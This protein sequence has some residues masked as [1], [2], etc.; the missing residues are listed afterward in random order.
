MRLTTT[1]ITSF[2]ALAC[3]LPVQAA[4]GKFTPMSPHSGAATPANPHAGM[5]AN[6]HGAGMQ[7]PAAQGLA[8]K[9][10][11]KNVLDVPQFTYIEADQAGKSVWIAAPTTKLKKGDKI[12]YDNGM[13]MNNFHSKSLKRDFAS[14][15]F[16][17]AVTVE[18]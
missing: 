16:V 15:I 5:P 14:V 13:V 6:P 2:F 3:A 7:A 8:G 4:D 10:S 1:L 11:V 18:K 17:S 9:A 12:R